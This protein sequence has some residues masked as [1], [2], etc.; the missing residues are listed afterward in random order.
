VK[1][2]EKQKYHTVRTVPT[3]NL[4]VL[5]TSKID[6]HNAHDALPI[7]SQLGTGTLIESDW[8]KLVL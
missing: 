1:N 4:S 6:N 8:V 2:I 7:I 3:S 5:E